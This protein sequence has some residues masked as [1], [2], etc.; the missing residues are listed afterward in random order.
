MLFLLIETI[1][2]LEILKF[3]FIILLKDLIN[4]P[5]HHAQCQ[6][7]KSMKAKFIKKRPKTR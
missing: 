3:I 7:K 2:L 5:D 4:S 1:L 6:Y